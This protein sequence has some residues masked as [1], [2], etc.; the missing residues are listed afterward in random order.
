MG[1]K[2]WIGEEGLLPYDWPFSNQS[3]EVPASSVER[4][5]GMDR[6]IALLGVGWL[7]LP[8]PSELDRLIGLQTSIINGIARRV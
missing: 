5:G 7:H 2:G 3:M 4:T 1:T 6:G 8:M